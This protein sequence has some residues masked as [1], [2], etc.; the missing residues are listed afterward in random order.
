MN[1]I[2]SFI[3]R[4]EANNIFIYFEIVF[5]IIFIIFLSGIL[6]LLLKASWLKRRVLESIIEFSTYR[7]FGAKKTFKEWS[8]IIKR[9]ESGKESE[10]KLAIIEADNLLDDIFGK[11]GY[12]GE[13][14]KE[15]LEQLGP[16]ILPSID[17]VYQVHKIRNNI[18]YDPDYQ[19]TLDRAKKVLDIYEKT[20]RDLELF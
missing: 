19:L 5:K 3:T 8:K 20:F 17:E 9:L 15:K 16:T 6:I 7:P 4:P 14:M 10:C 11:M 1:Q 12:K 13:T 2:F 18:V